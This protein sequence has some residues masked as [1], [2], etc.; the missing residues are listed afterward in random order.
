MCASVIRDDIDRVMS[1]DWTFTGAVNLPTDTIDE[2][3]V[4]SAT[5]F[6]AENVEHRSPAGE[7]AAQA[8]GAAVAAANTIVHVAEYAGTIED[9]SVGI[10]TAPTTTD[11]VTIDLK[12]STGGGAWAT[13]L[14]STIQFTS[15]DS[16]RSVK[17]GT[18]ST[19]TFAAD[20]MLRVEVTVSG[21]SAQGIMPRVYLHENPTS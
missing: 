13:V 2:N 20:D 7:A 11:T 5:L 9:F 4:K 6:A 16:D 3:N 21:S 12:K 18:L 8:S 10:D 19:T 17:S 15:S 14:S 1:G